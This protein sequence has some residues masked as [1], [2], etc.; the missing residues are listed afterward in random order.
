ML[1]IAADRS[2]AGSRCGAGN[3]RS[4]GG[5]IGAGGPSRYRTLE[6][7]ARESWLW[8]EDRSV[9]LAA[10]MR[11]ID[12]AIGSWQVRT[13]VRHRGASYERTR[14]SASACRFVLTAGGADADRRADPGDE[15]AADHGGSGMRIGGNALTGRLRSASAGLLLRCWLAGGGLRSDGLR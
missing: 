6:L 3:R 12:L 11:A 13:R 10:V 1:R 4:A 14:G 5:R 9:R 7:V 15:A 8:P 2:G